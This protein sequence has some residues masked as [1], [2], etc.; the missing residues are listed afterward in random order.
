MPND[1][2]PTTTNQLGP[3]TTD[4]GSLTR[5]GFLAG[6]LVSTALAL[7]ACKGGAQQTQQDRVLLKLFP[8]D[9][10]IA[11]GVRDRLPLA[12]G[13]ETGM[14]VALST[15]EYLHVE[16]TKLS[17]SGAADASPIAGVDVHRQGRELPYPYYP[18]RFTFAEPGYYQLAADLSNQTHT[19]T[20]GVV[21]PSQTEGA[22]TGAPVGELTST[23]QPLV[24]PPCSQWPACPLHERPLDQLLA[25]QRPCALVLAVTSS[26]PLGA[27]PTTTRHHHRSQHLDRGTDL[28]PRSRRTQHSQ[29]S[30]A[31]PHAPRDHAD[32]RNGT[33]RAHHK[34]RR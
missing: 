17:A 26:L 19:T 29:R 7:T 32:P 33:C 15:P 1:P 11:A 23:L 31:D 12:F 3:R 10:R 9:G 4:S 25:A 14:P 24:S 8:S 22:I 27:L 30:L 20:V 34:Q 6:S 5:R 2:S 13:D 21:D 18:L 28:A 16:I